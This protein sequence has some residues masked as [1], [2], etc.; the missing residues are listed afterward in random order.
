MSGRA[1]CEE[2]SLCWSPQDAAVWKSRIEQMGKVGSHMVISVPVA[3]AAPTRVQTQCSNGRHSVL[4][5]TALPVQSV[6]RPE[7]YG[8]SPLLL[9]LCL[10]ELYPFL[11][12]LQTAECSQGGS[13][14]V[15]REGVYLECGPEGESAP[16][17]FAFASSAWHWLEKSDDPEQAEVEFLDA[18]TQWENFY[19]QCRLGKPLRAPDA[20]CRY[21]IFLQN[22]P[23]DSLHWFAASEPRATG[24]RRSLVW[25]WQTMDSGPTQWSCSIPCSLWNRYVPLFCLQSLACRATDEKQ[26]TPEPEVTVLIQFQRRA[27]ECRVTLRSSEDHMSVTWAVPSQLAHCD[28]GLEVQHLEHRVRLADWCLLADAAKSMKGKQEVLLCVSAHE[29]LCIRF[30]DVVY[31][32]SADVIPSSQRSS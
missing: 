25:D 16:N 4:C 20:P 27:D 14:T 10:Y 18:P 17:L 26:D 6:R 12:M 21:R 19:S 30:Q 23:S 28:T 5:C 9:G 3:S 24:R 8:E 32:I 29:P 11:A 31:W 15:S 22:L 7:R 1:Q 13:M 2:V